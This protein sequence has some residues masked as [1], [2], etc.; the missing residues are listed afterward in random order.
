MD[1]VSLGKTLIGMGIVIVLVGLFFVF[2]DRI[3]GLDRVGRLPGDI[4]FKKGDASFY[5]PLTT[6]LLVSVLLSLL[7]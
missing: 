2:Q 5:F 4:Y 6:S 7:M 1:G 3:P